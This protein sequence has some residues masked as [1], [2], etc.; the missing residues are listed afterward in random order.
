[1]RPLDLEALLPSAHV[2]FAPDFAARVGSLVARLAGA[3]RREGRG[4]NTFLGAGEEFVGHRP[5]RPGEDLRG[6]DWNLLARLDRPYVRVMR[7]E[8][9]ERWA[10]LLDASASMGVGVPGKLSCAAQVAAA[11]AA[12]G[13]RAGVHVR[14]LTTSGRDLEVTRGGGLAELM[15]F[16]EGEVA[17]GDAGLETLLVPAR[18]RD[19][20]RVFAIGDLFGVGVDTPARVARP[21]RELACLWIL[22]AEELSPPFTDAVEW[23]DPETGEEL[24]LRV[25]PSTRAAY[26]AEL[27]SEL[28]RWGEVA[29][30]HRMRFGAWRSDRAFEDIARTVLDP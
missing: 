30:R 20:G 10:V 3:E 2:R 7:R 26:E 22:A 16:L 24:R 28:E 21:G 5:Y 12:A 17:S 18:L 6:L 29:G 25:D 19:S 14:V 15:A 11:V 13:L 23:V 8:A 1:M 4:R 9:S 27:S